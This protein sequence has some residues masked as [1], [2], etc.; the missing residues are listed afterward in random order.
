MNM[1]VVIFKLSDED[2]EELRE[3][4]VE[5]E[6]SRLDLRVLAS[7]YRMSEPEAWNESVGSYL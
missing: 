4:A 5:G 3:H 7:C 2:L 1:N 6:P